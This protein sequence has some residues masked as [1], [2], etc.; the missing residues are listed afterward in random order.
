MNMLYENIADT[1][2]PEHF[3]QPVHRQ[4]YEAIQRLNLQGQA[5][6]PISIG[7]LVK[8]DNLNEL[9]VSMVTNVL[10]ATPGGI[11]THAAQLYDLYIRRK[12]I[13]I[14]DN[15]SAN[16]FNGT[17]NAWSYLEE[18]EQSLFQIAA[19]QG[20][21]SAPVLIIK[22]VSVALENAR[23]ARA[24]GKRITGIPTGLI[25]LDTQLGGLHNSDIVIIASR[26][27]MG[28]TALGVC[29][30]YNAAKEGYPTVFFSLEMSSDQLG[31]RL[32]SQVARV[33]SDKIRCGAFNNQDMER[34]VR[35]A[36]DFN[37]PL[38]IEDS[39]AI[40]L[41]SLRTRIRRMVR[42]HKIKLVVLD[43]LQLLTLGKHSEN[44]LQEISAI[45]RSLKG[46][47][48][49]MQIPILA[50][51]QLSRAVEQRDDKKPQL[52]DLRESGTIEQDADVVMFIYRESYYL[53]RKKPE[54]GSDKMHEWQEKMALYHNQAEI[55]I[56]KQRHGPIGTVQLHYD[57]RWTLFSNLES[58]R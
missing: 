31:G 26:P 20:D 21:K 44:R 53:S 17:E 46:M 47:A 52:A 41:Q 2:I 39:P 7:H 10:A 50:L 30:A 4:I 22:A 14:S 57:A 37:E 32:L 38:F 29:I 25:D 56:A 18:A 3:A 23:A 1:V 49:E 5:I 13:G 16:A 55:L 58:N 8:I 9:I 24:S 11:T 15:L 12:L 43:Y 36:Q 6:T 33:P 48:K 34:L 40:T 19:D 35:S 42:Q 54:D 27:S 51:S 45:T 28:K